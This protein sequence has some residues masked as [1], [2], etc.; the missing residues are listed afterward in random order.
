MKVEK[1]EHEKNI[2]VSSFSYKIEPRRE[3]FLIDHLLGFN[4]TEYFSIT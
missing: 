2:S 1:P 4:T 3:S